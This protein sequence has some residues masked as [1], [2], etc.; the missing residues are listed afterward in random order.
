MAV[1]STRQRSLRITSWNIKFL[2]RLFTVRMLPF[3]TSSSKASF[4]LPATTYFG[5]NGDLL[6]AH[7]CPNGEVI[8]CSLCAETS[9]G[10][11]EGHRCLEKVGHGFLV[12]RLLY[13]FLLRRARN[14][15]SDWKTRLPHNVALTLNLT[16]MRIL[17]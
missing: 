7:E 12:T 3:V 17:P 13:Y 5:V 15:F 11:R 9:T 14:Q 10:K 8:C 2:S 6:C 4:Q 1:N 16:M